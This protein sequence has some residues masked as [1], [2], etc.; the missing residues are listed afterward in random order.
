MVEVRRDIGVIRGDGSERACR[1]MQSRLGRDVALA[2]DL[3]D[4]QRVLRWLAGDGHRGVGPGRRREQGHAR[5]V[6][7]RERLVDGH[8]PA[9][10]LRG[11]W[12]AR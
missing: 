5:D 10:D 7:H 9:T 11:E 1:E 8:R 4:E 3:L 12:G 6:D 2:L